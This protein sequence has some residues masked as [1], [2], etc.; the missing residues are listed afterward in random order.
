MPCVGVVSQ[1]PAQM[2][3]C[4]T[5]FA[6]TRQEHQNVTE[7]RARPELV[8][9]VSD[10]VV[11]VVIAAFFKWAIAHFH[12]K[13][14]PRHHQHRGRPFGTGEMLCKPVR[15]DRGRGDDDF[16][17]GAAWQQLSQITQQKIDVQTALVRLV[18]DERV[19]RQQQRVGLRLGQQNTVGHQ[20]DRCVARQLVLESNFEADHLAQWR[21]QLF[22]DALGDG[23][24][25]NP[26][27]LGV[28]NDLAAF[29][30]R[31]MGEIGVRYRFCLLRK[32]IGI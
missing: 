1:M 13:Q 18:N 15:I 22:G 12:R 21:L 30:F 27:G 4:F 11:H 8:H 29:G 9:R 17:I 20:F 5:N 28:A 16:Q 25:G 26:P 24:R 23:R 2:F 19:I 6:L 31:E 7:R 10:G 32:K 14:A 3:S